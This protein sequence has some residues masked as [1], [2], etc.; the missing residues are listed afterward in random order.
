[1]LQRRG[2]VSSALLDIQGK[3]K[4]EEF[5]DGMP[6]GSQIA[7]SEKSAYVNT[8]IF[9][10]W[11][12]SHFLPRKP[13]GTVLLIVDGHTSHT[14]SVDMLDFC[15][16]NKIILLCLPSHTTHYLQP[17]DRSFFKSLKTNYYAAC[18]N[19][20]K[21]NPS[22]KLTRL[23]FGKLLG[24]AWGRSATVENGMSAFRATGISPF[25]QDAIP[26][27]A[28]VEIDFEHGSENVQP[29]S[30]N[31]T[32][33]PQTTSRSSPQPG[34]SH[35]PDLPAT[36]DVSEITPGKLLNEISPVPKTSA[37]VA[38]KKRGR[39]LA[40]IL[41]TAERIEKQKSKPTI[42]KQ[43]KD[44]E[45]IKAFEKKKERNGKVEHLILEKKER[46]AKLKHLILKME[47]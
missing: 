26:D 8:V 42:K 27:Y 24:H 47:V 5:A 29:Q 33:S 41:N 34:C 1:M 13:T 20:M 10:H 30:L 17:L 7:M 6:P 25:N 22:R 12:E 21:T 11:L 31:S 44:S 2:N 16:D 14:N 3:N 18:N 15:Q 39:Q 36:E 40:T 9:K 38:V 37:T 28:Y 35:Y 4:K 19:F 43:R 32:H 23:Q 45:E 46:S